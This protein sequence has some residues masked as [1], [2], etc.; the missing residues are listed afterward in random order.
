MTACGVPVNYATSLGNWSSETSFLKHCRFHP[1]APVNPRRLTDIDRHDLILSRAHVL[2]R[3]NLKP[4]LANPDQRP[5]DDTDH[6]IARALPDTVNATHWHISSRQISPT[7]V[8][9]HVNSQAMFAQQPQ[10]G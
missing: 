8:I 5:S 6:A 7:L 4:L 1:M 2:A 3:S 10:S 9:I